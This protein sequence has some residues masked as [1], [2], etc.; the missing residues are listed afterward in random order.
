M[1]DNK[2]IAIVYDW[3]DKWGGVERVL[4]TM[5]D[6]FPRAEFFTSYYNP[7]TAPWAK[8]LNIRTSFIQGLPPF[9]R[10]NRL[11]SLPLYPYAF[12]SFNFNGYDLVVSITSSFAKAVITRPETVH[13]SYLLTPTR[14]LWS[15]ADTYNN[16][17]LLKGLTEPYMKRLREWDYI[18]SRRPDHIISISQTVAERCRKYYER[19]SSVIYP[20]FDIDYW[21]NIKLKIKNEKLKTKYNLQKYFLVVS[22]LEKYKRVDLVINTFNKLQDKTLVVVGKG[23]EEK[24][25]KSISSDNI[26]F[27]QD[28]T[29]EDLANFYINAEALIMPQEEDFGYVSLEA[30]FYGCPVLSYEKG[31]AVETVLQDKTGVF[32]TEQTTQSLL[33]ILERFDLIS[34]NLKTSTKKEGPKNV[35]RFAKD[36]FKEDLLTFLGNFISSKI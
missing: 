16:N 26:T 13:V 23:S 14:F 20:P 6:I 12:E 36:T 5:H 34:Y 35:K 32:F 33:E 22:R 24:Y 21:K 7:Q 15:H 1:F 19:E 25:L 11:L 30:Q 17:P 4:L 18:A 2:K 27:L 8:H 10:K 31:G 28:I 29:D 3:L 9:I